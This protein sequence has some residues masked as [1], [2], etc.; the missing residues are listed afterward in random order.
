MTIAQFLAINNLRNP[1]RLKTHAPKQN[2]KSTA[3]ASPEHSPIPKCS[4]AP[5][6]EYFPVQERS[7]VRL[8]SPSQNQEPSPLQER[9]PAQPPSPSHHQEHSPEGDS[10]PVL[11]PSPSPK[12]KCS[13]TLERSSSSTFE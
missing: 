13:P 10:S 7:P 9:S 12:T 2:L 4:P 5:N 11:T 1:Q 6:Q 8:P 3:P